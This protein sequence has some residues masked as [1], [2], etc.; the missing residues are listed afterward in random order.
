M[1]RAE[2]T[3]RLRANEAVLRAMGVTSLSLFGSVARGE[4]GPE[5]DVDV[6][7]TLDY[8]RGIDLFDFLVM[9]EHVEALLGGVRVDVATEPARTA[10]LQPEIDRDRVCVW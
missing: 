6:A 4:A 8:N 10:R 5:S 2:I 1:D 7:V 9:R 3:E